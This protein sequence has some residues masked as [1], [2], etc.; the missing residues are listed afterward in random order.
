MH[1]RRRRG[2][3]VDSVMLGD[4]GTRVSHNVSTGS[5]LPLPSDAP[6]GEGGRPRRPL[7]YARALTNATARLKRHEWRQTQLESQPQARLRMLD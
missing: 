7:D 3:G 6:G 1:G 4:L 2:S 5:P